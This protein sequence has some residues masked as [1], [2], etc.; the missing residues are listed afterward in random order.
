[1]KFIID[2]ESMVGYD[3]VIVDIYNSKN[4]ISRHFISSTNSI[5]DFIE[6]YLIECKLEMLS[7]FGVSEWWIVD[8]NSML[9]K[10][11]FV[12]SEANDYLKNLK[13]SKESVVIEQK[14]S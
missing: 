11:F 10:Q 13:N 3:S 7:A 9:I 14:G 2:R 8:G 1:M 12:Y 5:E 4:W 6:S